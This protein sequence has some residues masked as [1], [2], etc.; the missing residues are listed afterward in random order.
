MKTIISIFVFCA[1]IESVLAGAAVRVGS[2]EAVQMLGGGR[3]NEA[4]PVGSQGAYQML[5]GNNNAVRV[6]SEEAHNLL[7][8]NTGG[9]RLGSRRS[10]FFEDNLVEDEVVVWDEADLQRALKQKVEKVESE[11]KLRKEQAT[12]TYDKLAEESIK[13]HVFDSSSTFKECIEK[14]GIQVIEAD[15]LKNAGSLAKKQASTD[16]KY[17]VKQIEA[18]KALSSCKI[19]T[20]PPYYLNDPKKFDFELYDFP[21]I[22][23]KRNIITR[24]PKEGISAKRDYKFITL[25]K[26]P[27]DKE[28]K[29][30]EGEVIFVKKGL[31]L[32]VKINQLHCV[33]M[34]GKIP[35]DVIKEVISQ[36]NKEIANKVKK[37]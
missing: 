14:Y 37:E 16:S 10:N 33:T 7:K 31:D 1:I 20:I 3:V 4:V 36:H 34:T 25:S 5:G 6:G 29:F 9:S 21:Q 18:N 11:E 17:I 23:Y 15:S 26:T 19:S 35:D 22:K 24:F 32:N 8:G 2:R 12:A 30:E 28:I 13:K 27:T